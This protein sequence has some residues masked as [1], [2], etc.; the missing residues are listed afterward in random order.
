M[1]TATRHHEQQLFFSTGRRQGEGV[2]AIDGL[3]LRPA[4][5]ARYRQLTHLRYDF[6]LVL[7]DR[8]PEAGTI[9]PLS[10][11]VD[12]VLQELAPKGIGGERLRKYVLRLEREV[13]TLLAGGATG[14]LS[15]LWARAAR[16]L[17]L[18][19]DPSAA[20]VLTHIAEKLQLDGDVVDC[21]RDTP[22]RVLAHAWAA[23]QQR[24]AKAFRT[25]AE[26]LMV[27]LSDVLRAAF[28]HSE[29]G[30]QPAALRASLGGTHRDV[31]DFAV[32]SRLVV[33]NAPKDE[34]PASRRSRIAWALGILQSQPFFP[35]PRLAERR[36]S[37]AAFDFRFDNCAA[38]AAAYRERLPMVANVVKALSIAELEVDGAYDEAKHDPFFA[39]FDDSA[40]SSDDI[41]MFPDYLVCIPLER[42][43][44]PENAGLMDVLSAGLPVKVLVET[45]DLL[46]EAPVGTGHFA[47]GV[48]STRLA[49]TATGLGGVFVVQT[50]SSN[51][52]ALG[53]PLAR[54]FAHR[55]AGLVCVYAGAGATGELPLYLTAAAAM[56]SRAFPAFTYDPYA[57]DNIAARFSLEDNPQAAADWPVEHFEY[58]DESQ[59]R[60]VE[61]TPFTVADFVLCD[62]RHAAHFA[63]VPRERWNALMIPAD[64]WLA[65]EPKAG[66]DAIPFVL[67]IDAD[68][69]L[70]RVI[71]DARMMQMVARARTFWHRLQEQGGVH[72]SHA[73]ILLARE[74]AKWELAKAD[75]L[76][77]LKASV[78]TS[79]ATPAAATVATPVAGAAA[80][81]AVAG[82]APAAAAEAAKAA[83]PAPPARNPDEAWIDTA[84]CPSCNECQTINDKMFKYNDNKQAYIA[85]VRAGTFRQMVEAAEVC[86]VSIIH[87]GKPWNPNEPGLPELL[88]RAASFE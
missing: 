44:A 40:L 29:A 22:A 83:E 8:G 35:D 63:R 85:D 71:V 41:A 13:R 52:H 25:L 42:N 9:R 70:Q 46:E 81:P 62:P 80:T 31:F 79:A 60:V 36:E 88:E 19:D 1:D 57:G 53:E 11:V 82:T 59:Q 24:K 18:P 74:K 67:A 3:A 27:K 43:D 4:L 33:R 32:M 87:P 54:A 23:A 39:H 75:E 20:T 72:N 5:L 28:I 69:R 55:G 86:Q 78:A 26:R 56:E 66:G 15:E 48:R 64:E 77:A 7:V 76:D 51:L 30:Q 14:T 65:R 6:P 21:D 84:R 37:P 73:E 58:A 34:L 47:F 50:T 49:N 10:S 2:D 17:A 16:E 61:E 38:A 12:E 68:D 45:S